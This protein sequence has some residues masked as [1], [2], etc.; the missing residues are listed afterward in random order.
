MKINFDSRIIGDYD[1]RGIYPNQINEKLFYIFGRS[2]SIYFNRKTVAV[3]H[4]ARLSSPKLF[5]ALIKGLLEQGSDVVSLGQISTEIHY[6]ASGYYNF[7]VNVIV[8]A[9]HNPAEY[10]GLKIVKQGVIPLNGNLGLPEIKEIAEKQVFPKNI[11][12]GHMT[13]KNITENWIK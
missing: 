6:F 5:E 9:S 13:H 4:D 7:P 2:I 8:S 12:K 10:N 11:K 3:G 1:I